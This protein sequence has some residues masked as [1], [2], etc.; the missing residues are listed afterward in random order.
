[1]SIRGYVRPSVRPYVCR[2]SICRSF[3]IAFVSNPQKR[4]F[5]PLRW[6]L[7]SWWRCVMR[8]KAVVT[9]GAV[10][11]MT[12]GNQTC[13]LTSWLMTGGS[14]DQY[15]VLDYHAAVLDQHYAYIQLTDSGPWSTP[16]RLGASTEDSFLK[17]VGKLFI[18][19]FLW[20]IVPREVVPIQ[21]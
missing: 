7:I 10:V 14:L 3:R 9:R 19:L 11:M 4:L 12:F 8:G 21:G 16:P 20:A 18:M 1:M 17:A 6:M 2:P 13:W 15:A 5:W